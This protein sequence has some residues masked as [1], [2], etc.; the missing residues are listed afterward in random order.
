MPRKILHID[1]DAFYCAVE[2]IR[3]PS[4][5]GKAFAVGGKPNERGVVA[6]C[7]YAARKFGVRSAMPMARAVRLCPGLQVIPGHYSVYSKYSKL[8]MEK[9]RDITNRVEQISIDE[10]FLDLSET[11]GTALKTAQALQTSILRDLQ[12]PCSIGIG[13]NKLVAKIATDVGKAATQADGPPNAIQVVPP[14]QEAA[15]LAPLPVERL[16]GVGPK[17]TL[18]LNQIGV[19]TIEQLARLPEEFLE[20]EFG[21]NGLDLA[22]RSI[23]IDDR[24]VVTSHEIKSISKENTFVR[25]L[26]EKAR[27]IQ[28]LRSLTDQLCRR[29]QRENIFGSTVKLKLRWADFTTLTR[30]TTLS[31]P[32]DQFEDIFQA[33]VGLFE[34][35]WPVGKPVR[36]IGIGLSGLGPPIRQL[37]LWEVPTDRQ[38]DDKE[39][40]LQQ[41]IQILQKRFGDNI[42]R[43]GEDHQITSVETEV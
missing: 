29:V 23:G 14:G 39:D 7:S 6:S 17:T 4:L 21:K 24:P 27:L 9:L 32:T 8:V 3:E 37:S 42:L 5:R 18:R 13:A 26:Q 34:G 38:L 20:K 43:R 31:Q 35:N 1:L 19:H 22:R 16:W 11:S 36:L 28:E 33:A 12:L 41:A 15:F 30:Q 10:A 40:R 2:E 25:D